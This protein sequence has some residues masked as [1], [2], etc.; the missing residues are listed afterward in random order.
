MFCRVLYLV[1]VAYKQNN[2][3]ITIQTNLL[4]TR[5]V[6][7][8]NCIWCCNDMCRIQVKLRCIAH[9]SNSMGIFFGWYHNFSRSIFTKLYC[10]MHCG[11][12]WT[13]S[14]KTG[15]FLGKIPW[16]LRANCKKA[17]SSCIPQDMSLQGLLFLILTGLAFYLHY[18][19]DEQLACPTAV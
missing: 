9:N 2:I 11:N 5:T 16:W 12:T 15:V 17:R 18:E 6:K 3:G 8:H 10:G 13:P 7:I 14:E 19:F 4:I 1:V